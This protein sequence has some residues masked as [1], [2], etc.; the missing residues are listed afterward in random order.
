MGL[1]RLDKFQFFGL[2]HPGFTPGQTSSMK[3]CRGFSFPA[4]VWHPTPAGAGSPTCPSRQF[5]SSASRSSAAR[6]RWRRCIPAGSG[7]LRNRHF[8]I[9]RLRQNLLRFLHRRNRRESV[10]HL[11]GLG[12]GGHQRQR[13]VMHQPVGEIEV[14]AHTNVYYRIHPIRD[15]L[16]RL[17]NNCI[18]CFLKLF[19]LYPN[20]RNL[21]D[22]MFSN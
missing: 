9:L 21:F 15:Y 8:R 11:R 3:R 2:H 4:P 20:R 12:R 17:L 1:N 22:Q 18:F 16:K 14:L 19:Q 10:Q 5:H 13:D 7:F 6:C